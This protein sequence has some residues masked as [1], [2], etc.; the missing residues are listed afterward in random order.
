[1]PHALD[2][3]AKSIHVLERA[4][5]GGESHIGNFIETVQLLHRKLADEPRGDLA[6]AEGAQFMA[7]VHDGRIQCFARNGTLYERLEHA[8]AK[9]LLIEGLAALVILDDTRHDELGCFEGR[10][11]LAALEAFAAS[12]N[13]LSLTRQSRVDDLGFFVVAERAVHTLVNG[14]RRTADGEDP[15]DG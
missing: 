5:D 12:P 11:S 10:E 1:M 2:L 15:R 9:L 4:I 13:L 6:L 3:L 7:D 8:A 14:G